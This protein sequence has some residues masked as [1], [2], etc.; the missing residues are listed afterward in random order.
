MQ[1][2]E[3]FEQYAAA[4]GHADLRMLPLRRG[5]ASWGMF[6]TEVDG[7][8]VRMAR[9]GGPC[10]FEGSIAADG[11]ALMICFDGVGK[12]CGNGTPFGPYSVMVAPGGAAIQSTSLDVVSWMSVFIP[13]SRLRLGGIHARSSPHACRVFDVPAR[14]YSALKN[15]LSRVSI[16]ARSGAFEDNPVGRKE[17]A[18]RLTDVAQRIVMGHEIDMEYGQANGRPRRSRVEIIGRACDILE[19]HSGARIHVEDLAGTLGVPVRTLNYVFREQ[20]GISPRHFV[21]AYTLNAA[22]GALRLAEPGSI[23]VS[24]IAARFGIW[25]WG[26]FSRDYQQLFGELPSATLRRRDVSR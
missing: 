3:S 5:R 4:L 18:Q 8:T 25:E 15:V 26:R 19:A 17:A 7:L 1:D 22:R 21:R 11:F 12:V 23:R 24:D 14:D 6:S 20:M 9:D 10:L 16:A 2:F 13:A